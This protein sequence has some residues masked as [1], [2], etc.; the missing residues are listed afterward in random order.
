MMGRMAEIEIDHAALALAVETM[1]RKSRTERQRVEK[2]LA[3]R[4]WTEVATYCAFHCQV[5]R[6]NLPPWQVAPCDVTDIATALV[7]TDD[8]SARTGLRAAALLRQRM[9]R[10]GVS[11]WHPDPVAACQAAEAELRAAT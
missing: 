1:R 5:E 3:D 2:M 4:D 8:R 11:R 6:L 10:C 9:E 7:A